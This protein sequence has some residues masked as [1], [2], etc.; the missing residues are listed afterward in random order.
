MKVVGIDSV[1]QK[2]TPTY[3]L[4]INPSLPWASAETKE[5]QCP[6]TSQRPLEKGSVSHTLKLLGDAMV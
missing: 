6:L 1:R 3:F 2:N 5:R 4:E